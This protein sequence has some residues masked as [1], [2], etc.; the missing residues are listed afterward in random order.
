MERSSQGMIALIIAVL[1]FLTV[2]TTNLDK[3]TEFWNST[4]TERDKNISGDWNGLFR[5]YSV[6]TRKEQISSSHL[7]LN[8]HRGDVSGSSVSSNGKFR[9]WKITGQA[10]TIGGDNFLII[11]YSSKDGRVSVGSWVLEYRKSENA[12]MGYHVG[13]DPEQR[14]FVSYPHILTKLD[15][16]VAQSKYSDFLA[17]SVPTTSP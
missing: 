11:N 1:T 14:K 8:S 5:E 15:P 9:D 13:F 6:E 3:I 7:Q 2:V 16:E 17:S 12:F 4:F 10:T